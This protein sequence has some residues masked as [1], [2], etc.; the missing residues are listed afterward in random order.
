[1]LPFVCG[2]F[3]GGAVMWLYFHKSR[4]IRTRDEWYADP[5]IKERYGESYEAR[6]QDGGEREEGGTS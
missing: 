5:I 3:C 6:I 4:L 1:M 2:W